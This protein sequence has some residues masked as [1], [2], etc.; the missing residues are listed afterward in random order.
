MIRAIQESDIRQIVPIEAR[1]FGKGAWSYAMIR[2]EL[3]APARTYIVDIA[4]VEGAKYSNPQIAADAKIRGYGGFWYDGDD[5]ELMTIGVDE[6][7]QRQG[8]GT[9]I[10]ETLLRQ[11][12]TQG[13]RRM[14]LEVRVDNDIAIA[15]YQA[16]GFERIGLRKHYYQPE[17]I[18][19]YTMALDINEWQAT[20]ARPAVTKGDE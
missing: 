7:Y 13:V 16:F 17:G 9:A 1:L 10:L 19:A 5:A 12:A 3:N 18:D 20:V 2:Q 14:L 15:I 6:P 4:D 11:A 8:I